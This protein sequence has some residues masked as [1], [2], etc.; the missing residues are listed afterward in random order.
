MLYLFAIGAG[1]ASAV[2]AGCTGALVRGLHNP[3]LV[4]LVSLLGSV[5]VISG[6]AAVSGGMGWGRAEVATVPWW[7]WMAGACGAVVL[8]SQPVAAHTLGAASYIG[9]VVSAGVVASVLLDHFGG[10]GF[11]VHPAGVWPRGFGKSLVPA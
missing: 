9:L 1:L 11:A 10:L 4:V 7:A 3:Y 5:V 2:Q 8:L 6:V